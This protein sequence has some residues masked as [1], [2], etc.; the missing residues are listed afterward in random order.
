MYSGK[1]KDGKKYRIIHLP[2]GYWLIY[3]FSSKPNKRTGNVL[4][5]AVFGDT[6]Y[7]KNW[8]DKRDEILSGFKRKVQT[9]YKLAKFRDYTDEQLEILFR[10]DPMVG[11]KDTLD[12]VFPYFTP[13]IPGYPKGHK[14]IKEEFALIPLNSKGEPII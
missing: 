4:H 14:F 6:G 12:W 13:S 1:K 5:K 9:D 11:N 8:L 7:P 3:T 10:R 2:T